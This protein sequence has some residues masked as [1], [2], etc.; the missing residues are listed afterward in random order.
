MTTTDGV[1]VTGTGSIWHFT[2]EWLYLPDSPNATI[3]ITALG[4]S[5]D[6]WRDGTMLMVQHIDNKKISY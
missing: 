3:H 4:D 1:Q 2:Q 5:D 6:L